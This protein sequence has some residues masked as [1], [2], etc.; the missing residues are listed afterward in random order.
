MFDMMKMMGKVKEA[1]AK[2]KEAQ[3]SLTEITTEGEA[4]GGLVKAIVNGKK[5]LIDLQID[6]SLFSPQDKDMLKDL[7]VAATNI[8]IEKAEVLA[9]ETIKKATE[10][11][12]PTI[13]GMD[14]SSMM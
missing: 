9:K 4:G 11:L 6:E 2:M 12:L 7:V 1:Q 10:G 13:P 3:D 5:Q 8:A 14:L